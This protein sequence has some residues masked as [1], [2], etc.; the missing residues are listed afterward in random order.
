MPWSSCTATGSRGNRGRRRR[1][2]EEFQK[3][4]SVPMVVYFGDNIKTGST[5]DVHWGLDNW[6]VRLNLANAWADVMKKHGGD[7]QVIVLPEIGI[8]GNTHFLMADLNNADVAKEMM[9]W[10]HEKKLDR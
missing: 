4:L 2:D 7:V 9:R 8:K 1:T 5:P 3:L 10:M 6:R